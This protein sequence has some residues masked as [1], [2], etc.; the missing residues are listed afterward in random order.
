MFQTQRNGSLQVRKNTD[1]AQYIKKIWEGG[2]VELW[3]S[4]E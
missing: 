3:N 1:M 4:E 2:T